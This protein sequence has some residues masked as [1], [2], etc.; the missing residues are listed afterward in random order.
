VACSTC[1]GAALSS[2]RL[3]DKFSES[4]CGGGH[5]NLGRC[6]GHFSLVGRGLIQ[7][8]W[9]RERQVRAVHW[10]LFAWSTW[11]QLATVVAG[12]RVDGDAL[13]SDR[14]VSMGS[15]THCVGEQDR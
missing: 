10:P 6:S 9:W 7:P 13:V 12:T 11:A 15:T 1:E 8:L 4:H 14:S 3:V 5:K 2:D